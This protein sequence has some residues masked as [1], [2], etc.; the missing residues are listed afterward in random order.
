MPEQVTISLSAMITLAIE[1]WRLAAWVAAAKAVPNAGA[2]RHA[3]RHMEDFLKSAELE[4]RSLDGQS[5]D[6]GMAALVVHSEENPR[7]PE[8]TTLIMETVAPIVLFRGQVVKSAEVVTSRGTGL[9][10]A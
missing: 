9:K 1:H 6:P 4:T 10:S 7:L 5:F 3:L 2:A 8:G